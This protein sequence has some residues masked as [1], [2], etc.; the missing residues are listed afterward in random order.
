MRKTDRTAPEDRRPVRGR[1][2][3]PS[4]RGEPHGHRPDQDGLA[5][6]V[7]ALAGLNP[8]N[9]K[10]ASNPQERK[11]TPRQNRRQ[12][13]AKPTRQQ[14]RSGHPVRRRRPAPHL[15]HPQDGRYNNL[16]LLPELPV[17][18]ARLLAGQLPEELPRHA[19]VLA[20]GRQVVGR[21]ELA[22]V[23]HGPEV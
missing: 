9:E 18:L 4:Q 10:K 13:K 21:P 22:K 5:Q 16:R 7:Q 8:D 2:A 3:I 17:Q 15:P 14:D 23:R 6:E 20:V 1:H 11:Y 12:D 19:P